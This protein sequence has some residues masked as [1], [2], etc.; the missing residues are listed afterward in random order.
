MSVWDYDFQ[1]N[2]PPWEPISGSEI[3][4]LEAKNRASIEK[5]QSRLLLLVKKIR[6]DRSRNILEKASNWAPKN[7]KDAFGI[8][9]ETNRLGEEDLKIIRKSGLALATYGPFLI[10][11]RAEKNFGWYAQVIEFYRRFSELVILKDSFDHSAYLIHQ[12]SSDAAANATFLLFSYSPSESDYAGVI[13]KGEGMLVKSLADP[14]YGGALDREIEVILL[15]NFLRAD[16][17]SNAVILKGGDPLIDQFGQKSPVFIE[18][19]TPDC[20]PLNAATA[21][22]LER[23]ASD[24]PESLG[25]MLVFDDV[26]GAWDRHLGNYLVY[27]KED[28]ARS[29]QEIDF[30]LFDPIW[31]KPGNYTGRLDDWINSRY[32][33]FNSSRPG[34]DI[35]RHPRVTEIIKRAI[36]LHSGR[37]QLGIEQAVFQL[38]LGWRTGW[39]RENFSDEFVNR[40]ESFFDINSGLRFGFQ[41]DLATLGLH[42]PVN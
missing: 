12:V 37:V 5:L 36:E 32:S 22:D 9:L 21:L 35:T 29:I 30:G 8:F 34:W 3:N 4:I 41:V 40:V 14:E 33:S 28:G 6:D 13:K 19:L 24:S 10:L 17:P 27:T 1:S 18:T 2:R 20:K 7:E 39:I 23:I 15:G 38:S 16:V 42:D 11:S 26:A 31:I 25:R